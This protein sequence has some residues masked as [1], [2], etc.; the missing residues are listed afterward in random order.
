MS[1][2]FWAPEAPCVQTRPYCSEPDYVETR[3]ELPE[4]NVSNRNAERFFRLLGEPFDCCGRWSSS[5]HDRVIH[6]LLWLLN[7][8]DQLESAT[9]A[10]S[11]EQVA[12]VSSQGQLTKI[13]RLATVVDCGLSSEQLLRYCT[14]LLDLLVQARTRGFYVSWA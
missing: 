2:T 1:I 3:S 14:V 4:L 6:R 10:P 9:L 5:D 8:P 11:R 12:A 13:H 7:H